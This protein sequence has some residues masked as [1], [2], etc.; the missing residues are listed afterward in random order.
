ME[1]ID[2]ITLF[3]KGEELQGKMRSIFKKNNL[4]NSEL[5]FLPKED[6][7]IWKILHEESVA[8]TKK[9]SCHINTNND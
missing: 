8:L 6:F 2:L 9:I 3:K 5:Q 1:S 4:D 7:E